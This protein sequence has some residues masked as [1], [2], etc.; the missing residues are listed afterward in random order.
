MKTI[1][2]QGIAGSYS[3]EAA[4]QFHTSAELIECGDFAS[5]FSMLENGR[6]EMAVVPI[7]NRIIGAIE[8]VSKLVSANRVMVIERLRLP[9]E[10]VLAGVE[11]STVD[12]VETV[13]SHPAALKQCDRFLS[14]LPGC[15][16]VIGA[17]TAA[18]VREM[19]KS[20]NACAAAIGSRRAAE[21]YGAAILAENIADMN[22]NWTEFILIGN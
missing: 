5:V 10:H 6:A 4:R 2:I 7:E 1:A 14:R 13:T 9:V 21:I 8:P 15:R 11:G 20:R 12:S 19:A 3:E 18:S 16:T 22:G 17:D